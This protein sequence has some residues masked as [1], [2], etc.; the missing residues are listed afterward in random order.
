MRSAAAALM[1]LLVPD[2]EARDMLVKQLI[3][4]AGAEAAGIALGAR[5]PIM[6]TSRA[7]SHVA[8]LASCALAQLLVHH[9][10]NV[11]RD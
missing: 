4:L 3:Y 9:R 8:R 2:L 6:L 1:I 11:P 10:L 5:I 7:D